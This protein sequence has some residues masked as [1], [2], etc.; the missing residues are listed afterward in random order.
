MRKRYTF[1]LDE[2]LVEKTRKKAEADRRSLSSAIEKGMDMYN[3]H[4]SK[5]MDTSVIENESEK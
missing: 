3:T 5:L 2:E 1:G 4:S